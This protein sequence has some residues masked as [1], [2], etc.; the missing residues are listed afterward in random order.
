[1]ATVTA[2]RSPILGMPI[3]PG[4]RATLA[5]VPG[6]TIVDRRSGIE[7]VITFAK[8][9]GGLAAY[10]HVDCVAVESGRR[11]SISMETLRTRYVVA[12]EPFKHFDREGQS[13]A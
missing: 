9:T 2:V 11:S 3:R 7:R 1:M 5:M 8:R 10:G 13:R 4:M 12:D 6:V